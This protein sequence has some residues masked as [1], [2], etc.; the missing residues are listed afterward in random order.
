MEVSDR[1]RAQSESKLIYRHSSLVRVTH[2]I[3]VLCLT[4]LL[5]SGLQIFNAHPRLY[6]GQYGADS[7][8]AI[9]SLDAEETD[10][11]VRGVTRIGSVAIPTTG[12][13]GASKVEGELTP[14]GFPSWL[15]L[16][17]YQDLATGRRWHFFFAWLFVF[18]GIC[19]LI[20][21]FLS[22]HVRRDLKP[23][24]DQLTARHFIQ[25]IADHARLRFARGDEARRYNALQKMAYLVV[26]FVLLPLMLATGLTMSPGID[27]A[28]PWLVDFF[29]GRQSARMIHFVTA[30]L[31]VAFV[32]IH[33]AMVLVSGVWNNLR[34]MITGYYVIKPERPPI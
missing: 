23:D 5:M 30:S 10:G 16:P 21:S 12:F 32:A 4:V 11:S 6:W 9:V 7:D 15:T 18:N 20:Y 26:I 17:S 34:S 13:L 27:A 28:L 8:P 31:I 14:R 1:G 2:W 3:N 19:Y 29:G 24:R 22:G 25:E 33:I